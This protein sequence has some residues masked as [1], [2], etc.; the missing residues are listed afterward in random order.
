MLSFYSATNGLVHSGKA[1]EACL[2]NA[3]A[4]KPE[5]IF[6]QKLLIVFHCT[7]GHNFRAL[8]DAAA[9][10]CPNATVAGCTC[11]GI[12]GIGGADESMR[13]LG[14]MVIQPG[15]RESFFVA[16]SENIRGY[17]S[18]EE[19]ENMAQSLKSQSDDINMIQLLASGIDIAADRAIKGIE[20]VFGAEVPIFG[21]T[22]SDN[23]KA[24]SS[25]Q[26][27]DGKILERGAIMIGYADPSLTV[28]MGVHHGSV[29]IGQPFRVTRSAA[30]RVYELD[31]KPAWPFLMDRLNLP[32]DTHPG[33]CIPVA[34]L[35][36]ALSPADQKAYDNDHILR[37]VVK[38]EEDGSFYMPVDCPEQTQ[39]WLTQR[40]EQL[41][42]EGLKKMISELVHRIGDRKVVA[43]FHTDCAARGRALFD[44]T[45]KEEILEIMQ[46]PIMKDNSVPW[47]GM[48][49]FGEFTRLNDKNLFHNYTTSIYA[50]VQNK[51]PA[52]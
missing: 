41:I 5:E 22:S 16:S 35:A 37:V 30:N 9:S 8:L 7:I 26:F 14:V 13:A 49:G 46:S 36:E 29:P 51:V 44:R 43:T 27:I 24:V 31:G 38:V 40:D 17:N 52:P 11:A 48:Y 10:L 25:Y 42:F 3:L 6:N 39:L 32:H 1:M 18:Y 21:G 28:E 2:R 45:A 34:G 20:S 47:L 15:T 4:N 33:P 23:V 12:V 19:A 50:L